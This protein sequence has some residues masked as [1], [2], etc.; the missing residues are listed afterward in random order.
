MSEYLTEQEQ[1]EQLKAWVKQYGPTI[2]LG[3]LIALIVISGF[4]YWQDYRNKVLLRA[5]AIY[6]E[7][8]TDRA[9]NNSTGTVTLATQ[10]I[11]HYKHTPYA[12]LAALMLAREAILSKNNQ[13]ALHHLEWVIRHGSN[14]SLREI[15]L[16]R[17]AR[18][19]IAN[20]Q[21]KA[22]LDQLTS[23]YDK[24]FEGLADEVKGDAYLAL[25]DSLSARK[26][27]EKALSEL[28]NADLIRPEL[29]MKIDDLATSSPTL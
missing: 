4:R 7:M 11:T 2:L 12:S 22:A 23:V 18:I 24:H 3:I 16:I 15:A 13:D 21:A 25:N 29:Q 6:D 9:N 20:N 10:L 14:N 26:A 19:L 5:S 8:I 1:V 28:P 27:Y 17:S